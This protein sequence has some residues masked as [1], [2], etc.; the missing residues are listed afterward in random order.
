M[1]K[2][3]GVKYMRTFHFRCDGYF[4]VFIEKPEGSYFHIWG[5]GCAAHAPG[6]YLDGPVALRKM[7]KLR[8][9]GHKEQLGTVSP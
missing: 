8:C 2:K 1:P 7:D 4:N 5:R 9:D 6:V 3:K